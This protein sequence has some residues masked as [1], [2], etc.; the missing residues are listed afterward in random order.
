MDIKVLSSI[1]E[2]SANQWNSLMVEPHPFMR[3]EFHAALERH[4]CTGKKFGWLPQH[5]AAFDNDKL[6]AVIPVYEKY[7]SYGEFVFD[8]AWADAYHRHGL[9]YYPKWVCASP[10][11][12]VS[13]P[14][15]LIDSNYNYQEVFSSLIK[16]NIEQIKDQSLSS[17]HYLFTSDEDTK[18]LEQQGFMR[19]LGCQFHWSNNNYKNFDDFLTTLTAKK[20][21]NIKQERRYAAQANVD[22]ELIPG[23]IATE[24]QLA[25]AELFYKKTF[26]EKYGTA[27]LNL[28]FF[29]EIANTM[30][31]QLLLIMAKRD[32]IY[33]AGAICYQDDET[34]YGRHWGC[35]EEHDHLH[36]EVC[37]Y[38]GIEYCIKKGLKNFEPGA[39]GEHKIS[40]GFLPRKTWSA[41]WIK[42]HDFSLA[43]QQF[44]QNE[45]KGMEYYF[46]DMQSR[47]PYKK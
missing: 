11:T 13:G 35:I 31:E 34:L 18:I 9:E 4:Q 22:I 23:N 41:H 15:V 36:F 19:R 8:M 44:L 37:Y 29:K 47:S 33:I 42:H 1:F 26:D 24:T 38:Q 39:Q 40:R 17:M 7:N 45:T 32:D 20:R 6:I 28:D 12:P 27:T 5:I 46:S 10:Y 2:I 30:G 3:Y 14:R 25:A 43:I 16:F 21:K